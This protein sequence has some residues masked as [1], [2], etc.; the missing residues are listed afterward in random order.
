MSSQLYKNKWHAINFYVNF[1]FAFICRPS[2]VPRS[3]SENRPNQKPG[4]PHFRINKYGVSSPSINGAGPSSNGVKPP[5]N[6][7]FASLRH[8][9]VGGQQQNGG[10]AGAIAS[11]GSPSVNVGHSNAPTVK[12]GGQRNGS[13][14]QSRG[15]MGI[16]IGGRS[17]G[18]AG[19]N[20]GHSNVLAGHNGG[21]GN[22]L[23]G[24]NDGH[25]NGLATQNGGH[26]NGMAAGENRS[27]GNGLPGGVDGGDGANGAA[28]TAVVL[29]RERDD[30]N[31]RLRRGSLKSRSVI[32][33]M[34]MTQ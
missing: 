30:P 25:G 5:S 33:S 14:S 4:N 13:A 12:N 7:P 29:R 9:L 3:K 28:G 10:Q 20:G 19:Q 17:N 1:R 23:P 34:F 27:H 16:Q 21:H 26:G 11:N 24:Q 31:R 8:P 18:L 15:R 6:D 2:P 32:I 22:R